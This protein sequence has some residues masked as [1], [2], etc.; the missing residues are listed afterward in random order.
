MAN[1]FIYGKY[2][3]E[4]KKAVLARAHGFWHKAGGPT[5]IL[6]PTENTAKDRLHCRLVDL[7]TW[8]EKRPKDVWELEH[9]CCS[10]LEVLVVGH[11]FAP[12]LLK[13]FGDKN[14][15]DNPDIALEAIKELHEAYGELCEIKFGAAEN[16]KELFME[17]LERLAP[18][19]EVVKTGLPGM[20]FLDPEGCY[21]SCAEDLYAQVDFEREKLGKF[22]SRQYDSFFLDSYGSLEAVE[23]VG[24][25]RS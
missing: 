4:P 15:M 9:V 7:E 19:N 21:K 3:W 25:V 14:L 1:L 24:Q 6:F 11:L 23:R 16:K 18:F 20:D 10:D 13:S 17:A 5:V 22:L 2:S 8:E 12:M